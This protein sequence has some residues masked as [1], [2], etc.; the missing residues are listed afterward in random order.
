MTTKFL[1]IKDYSELHTITPPKGADVYSYDDFTSFSIY[2]NQIFV[3]YQR[4]LWIVAINKSNITQSKITHV[5]RTDEK[6][7]DVVA[8]DQYIAI[9]NRQDLRVFRNIYGK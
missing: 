9:L 7:N 2:K 3:F 8:N 4:M 6:I 5:I 1:N